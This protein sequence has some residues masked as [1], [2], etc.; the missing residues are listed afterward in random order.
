MGKV[1]INTSK[2]RAVVQAET[3]GEL[4]DAAQSILRLAQ[5][6]C[7]VQTGRLLASHRVDKVSEEHMRISA[8]TPYA[9]DVFDGAQGR[10]PNRWLLR[11]IDRARM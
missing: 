4:E 6:E 9:R 8:N 3:Q 10:I 5:E 11:A 7:P 1:Q 2:A